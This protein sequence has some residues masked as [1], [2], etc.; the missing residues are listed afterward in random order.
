MLLHPLQPKKL[1]LKS[2][3]TEFEIRP[4]GISLKASSPTMAMGN[5]GRA[6]KQTS[7]L[8]SKQPKKYKSGYLSFA[9]SPVFFLV[10]CNGCS[11]CVGPQW[12]RTSKHIKWKQRNKAHK[13]TS[14]STSKQPKKYKSWYLP[15]APVFFLVRCNGRSHCV[16][17][18]LARFAVRGKLLRVCVLEIGSTF[19][20]SS[21]P[22]RYS[23]AVD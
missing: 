20:F 7:K 18:A 5:G 4:N 19:I 16:G 9:M 2:D 14:K 17:P 10:R 21:G 6:N 13:H 11:H 22:Q 1:N 3:H 12:K 23:W 8:T 15:F